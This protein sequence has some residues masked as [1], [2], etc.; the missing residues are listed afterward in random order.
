MKHKRFLIGLLLVILL[1]VLMLYSYQDHDKNNVQIKKYTKIFAD[2]ETYN[3]TEISFTGAVLKINKTNQT[4][5]VSIQEEPYTY[6]NIEINTSNVDIDISALKK[7]DLIDIVGIL[8]GENHATANKI[9]INESWKFNLII[10][11]SLLAIP[12]VMY[13]FFKTWKFD[14]K[15]I[16]FERRKKDA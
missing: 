12:F 1:I 5:L 2:F 11:R 16:R 3:N 6:P 7:N 9:W 10:V 8:D 15:K 14:W 4:I 13:L